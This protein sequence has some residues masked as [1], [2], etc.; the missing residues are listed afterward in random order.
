QKYIT[1]ADLRKLAKT[2]HF[3]VV[4]CFHVLHH[5]EWK[6]FLKALFEIG[7][8]I[9]IE[10][11]PD[12]DLFVPQKPQ[13]PAIAKHLRSLPYGKEIGSFVR[14]SPLIKD[15]MYLFSM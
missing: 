7:D 5:V 1:A 3:D 4:L 9:I 14:Q 12:N 10:T 8:H 11:P 13:I 15:H 6:P 2:H